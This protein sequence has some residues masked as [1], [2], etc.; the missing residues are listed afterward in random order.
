[1]TRRRIAVVTTTRAEYGLL[2]WLLKALQADPAVELQLIAGGAHLRPEFG[3]TIDR[4][5]EDGFRVAA[6]VDFLEAGDDHNATARS[7]AR[8]VSAFAAA[9]EKLRPQIVVLLGDRFELL[10]AA[11]AA[12]ALRIPIAH[13]HGGESTEGVLDEQVRHAI[14]KMAHLHFVAAEKYGLRVVQMGEDPNRVYLVGAPGLEYIERLEPLKRKELEKL[15]GISLRKPL[16]LMTYHPTPGSNGEIHE[17]LAALERTGARAVITY[18]NA[19]AGGRAVNAAI[20]TFARSAPHRFRAVS[21]LGQTG[22]LSLMRLSDAVFGNSSSGLLEAPT[23]RVPTVNIGDRQ[24]GRLRAPSVIDCPPRRAAMEK[25]LK[26]ALSASF[27][28][29]CVGVNPYVPG[30]V[31]ERIVRVLKRVD[32]DGLKKRFYDLGRRQP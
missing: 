13:I 2:Y 26:K 14:T 19:D 16:V 20:E 29:S 32:L 30:R 4:I 27:R 3:R 1:M 10:A 24:K 15:L 25:A 23:L 22:Y 17:A 11:S 21:S 28:K 9:Y 31:S 6:E 5:R 7:I 8:G 12:V 18:A